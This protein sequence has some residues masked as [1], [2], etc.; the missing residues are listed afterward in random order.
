LQKKKDFQKKMQ[1]VR[2]E[3][4][5]EDG[6]VKFWQVKIVVDKSSIISEEESDKTKKNKLDEKAE[7][8]IHRIRF[9]PERHILLE[10][11][12]KI[13]PDAKVDEEIITPLEIKSDFSKLLSRLFYKNLKS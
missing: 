12:K 6:K 4:N 10:E 5:P 11:A 7:E 1:V 2:A 8:E 3:I 13:K 9:N